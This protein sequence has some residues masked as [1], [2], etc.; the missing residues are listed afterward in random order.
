MDYILA[1]SAVNPL[2]K[3]MTSYQLDRKK[4]WIKNIKRVKSPNCDERPGNTEISLLVIHGISLPPRQYGGDYIDQ[5]F[6]NSLKP[7]THPYFQQIQDMHV[8]AHILID[9]VGN[10]TQYVPFHKRAWHAGE[11]EFQGCP[12][13]NDFSIG[14]ELEGS[15]DDPYE[16]IQYQKL[17]AITKIL[18][19]AWPAITPDRIS[20]H[21]NIAPGRKTDPGPYFDWDC[22]HNF[23]NYQ[24]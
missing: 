22:F 17:S 23:L 5:F 12:E 9:R 14:I 1:G 24:V 21:S 3:N 10:V 2:I 4:H 6:T 18:M 20:G 7:E 11:S 13:C 15:D 16:T 19:Q 8:S